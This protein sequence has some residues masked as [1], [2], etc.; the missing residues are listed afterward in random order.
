[1]IAS[2]ALAGLYLSLV[3]LVLTSVFGI[4]NHLAPGALIALLAGG[5]ALTGAALHRMD[6]RRQLL[7]GLAGLTTGPI[8]TVTFIATGDLLGVILGTLVA[9]VG[10]GA[11]FQPA[12]RMLLASAAADQRAELLSA[13]YVVSYLAFGVP[14]LIAGLVDHA[15][16]LVAAIVGYGVFVVIA[17]ATALVLA[18][19]T[20][21]R[22]HDD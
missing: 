3:P 11:G 22:Q 14:S 10:F 13:I 18:R 2:W 19:R 8:I 20:P 5:G 12:L 16:G 17:A 7:V 15:I 6:P 21:A 4:Q 9:G 1:M